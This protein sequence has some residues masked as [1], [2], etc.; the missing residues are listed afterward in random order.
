MCQRPNYSCKDATDD[1]PVLV[2]KYSSKQMLGNE[3]VGP[4]L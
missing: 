3:P 4:A 2:L 1:V